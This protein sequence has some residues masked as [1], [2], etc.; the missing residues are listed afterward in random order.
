MLFAIPELI[1]SITEPIDLF[2][3]ATF[4]ILPLNFT[5]LLII[6]VIIQG[7]SRPIAFALMNSKCE[8]LYFDT[9]S[10]LVEKF[11]VL[12]V[13]NSVMSDFEK[14]EK[15][16]L[17]KVREKRFTEPKLLRIECLF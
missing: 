16:A 7:K 5:Q 14:A 2:I 1:K 12:E 6:S 10:L 3:D 13:I 17:K 15:N 9:L 8:Q 4:S 11:P